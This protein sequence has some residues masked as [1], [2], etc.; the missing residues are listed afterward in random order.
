MDHHFCYW[1]PTFMYGCMN[2]FDEFY[3]FWWLI[4]WNWLGP[5]LAKFN[6]LTD[7]K[8]QQWNGWRL[9]D[10]NAPCKSKI[11][12]KESIEQKMK[13]F[14]FITPTLKL[15]QEVQLLSAIYKIEQKHRLHK[16]TKI[17]GHFCL[18]FYQ[19]PILS[20]SGVWHFWS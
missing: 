13:F 4:G 5:S 16:W 8:C 9:I 1:V 10:W 3:R 11:G 18:P 12:W 6:P 7:P 14:H 20:A 2:T 15:R 17:L 19:S